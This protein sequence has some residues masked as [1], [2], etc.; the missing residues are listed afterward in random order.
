MKHAALLAAIIAASLL[1]MGALSSVVYKLMHGDL[2]QNGKK[3]GNFS[4][5][6][7]FPGVI[8]ITSDPNKIQTG[9]W[10]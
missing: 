4:P 5:S 6:Q 3:V 7:K 9:L 2:I 1:G 8:E 10:N